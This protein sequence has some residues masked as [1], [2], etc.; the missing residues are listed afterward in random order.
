M[1][2]STEIEIPAGTN[3][4][5]T[6]LNYYVYKT[7]TNES[8]SISC[9]KQREVVDGSYHYYEE[10]TETNFTNLGEVVSSGQ[11]SNTTES[12]VVQLLRN[13]SLQ[14]TSGG[15]VVYYYVVLEYPNEE[16]ER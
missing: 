6:S 13:E 2:A 9:S 14:A 5:N 12:T 10:C 7:T 4:L 11:I 8:P 1:F 3:T 16:V 15:A